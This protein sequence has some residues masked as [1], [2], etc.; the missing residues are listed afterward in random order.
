MH[1]MSITRRASTRGIMH[2]SELRNSACSLLRQLSGGHFWSHRSWYVR[3][4]CI[5]FEQRCNLTWPQ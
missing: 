2:L 5:N 3:N 1:N 4:Y